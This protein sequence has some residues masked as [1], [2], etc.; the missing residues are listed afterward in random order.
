MQE[1]FINDE[2]LNYEKDFLETKSISSKNHS[3]YFI[4]IYQ[5]IGRYSR[6]LFQDNDNDYH[7][8]VLFED[9]LNSNINLNET[10]IL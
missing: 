9:F 1:E 4:D 8:N 6:Q 3:S 2:N 7:K 5:H 10:Y